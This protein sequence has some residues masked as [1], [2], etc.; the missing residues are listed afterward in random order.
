MS[1]PTKT[2]STTASGLHPVATIAAQYF[3]EG[4]GSFTPEALEN[5]QLALDELADKPDLGPA[6]ASL[7][8]VAQ[9]LEN[10]RKARDAAQALLRVAMTATF[11]LEEQNK[12]VKAEE[13]DAARIKRKAFS[14][15]S[16]N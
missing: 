9:H 10:D 8:R 3:L 14:K 16:G 12:K 13:E 15:F 2:D 4:K 7:V 1:A 11:A 5:L 6:V